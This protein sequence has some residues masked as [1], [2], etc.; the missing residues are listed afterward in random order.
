M[1]GAEIH[2]L[3]SVSRSQLK[4]VTVSPAILTPRHA[5]FQAVLRQDHGEAQAVEAPLGQGR[6]RLLHFSTRTG[7]T[8][9]TTLA[10]LATARSC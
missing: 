7:T 8:S 6:N 2:S 5:P 1:I 10:A 4:S 9:R 3:K